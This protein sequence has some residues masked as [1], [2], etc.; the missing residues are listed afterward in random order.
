[1]VQILIG[2]AETVTWA[3]RGSGERGDEPETKEAV[4]T[5]KCL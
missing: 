3:G 5:T 1:V 2:L 4:T